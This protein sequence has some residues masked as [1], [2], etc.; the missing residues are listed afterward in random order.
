MNWNQLFSSPK[1]ILLFC[2]NSFLIGI[3]LFMNA[4]G[5][6]SSITELLDLF[7]NSSSSIQGVF[8]CGSNSIF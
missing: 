2:L 5:L 1:N 7:A 8:S 3:S 4:A 6:W